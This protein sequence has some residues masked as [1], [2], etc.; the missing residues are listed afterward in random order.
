MKALYYPI[1]S[2]ILALCLCLSCF[3]LAGCKV[4]PE[5]NSGG[6]DGEAADPARAQKIVEEMAA[7][8]GTY[9]EI[10]TKK[11][12]LTDEQWRAVIDTGVNFVVDSDAHKVERVGDSALAEELF[13]RVDFPMERIKNINGQV[14]ELRFA[15]YKKEHGIGR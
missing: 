1:V 6:K 11:T 9:I 14:P 3:S 8:Y 10:N 15:A 12:H 2:C 5:S 4:A 13:K 7:D